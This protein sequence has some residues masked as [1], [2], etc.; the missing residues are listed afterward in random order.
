MEMAWFSGVGIGFRIPKLC[1]ST[2]KPGHECT[3]RDFEDGRSVLIGQALHDDEMK[4][5]ALILRQG[6]ESAAD[7]FQIDGPF[8][9]SRHLLRTVQFLE[10]VCANGLLAPIA[11]EPVVHDGQKPAANRSRPVIALTLC[12]GRYKCVLDQIFRGTRIARQ[13]ESIATEYAELTGNIERRRPGHIPFT[14]RRRVYS[15]RIAK[16]DAYAKF[17]RIIVSSITA[18]ERRRVLASESPIQTDIVRLAAGPHIARQVG[19]LPRS[20]PCP[21]FSAWQHLRG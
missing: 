13:R 1:T 9:L 16:I 20:P 19:T 12:N 11:D 7:L 4:R 21:L 2:G 5:G 8:L 10:F 6:I 14:R 3:H 17:E 18:F 15:N